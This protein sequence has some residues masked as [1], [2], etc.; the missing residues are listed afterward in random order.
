MFNI[1]N[2]GVGGG[3]KSYCMIQYLMPRSSKLKPR[4]GLDENGSHRLII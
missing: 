2:K 3:T 1:Y 4:E